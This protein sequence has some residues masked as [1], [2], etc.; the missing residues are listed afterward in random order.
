MVRPVSYSSSMA[1]KAGSFV[2]SKSLDIA[3]EAKTW[4]AFLMIN[5]GLLPEKYF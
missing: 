5:E 3:Y 2:N 4:S 1:W